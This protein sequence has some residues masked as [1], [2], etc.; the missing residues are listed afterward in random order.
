MVAIPQAARMGYGRL[1]GL[2]LVLLSASC[3][4]VA[5]CLCA[6]NLEV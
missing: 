6:W 2:G 5:E 3:D 1:Y 4:E